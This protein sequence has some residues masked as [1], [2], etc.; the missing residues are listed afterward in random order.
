MGI[1]TV[2][3]LLFKW[4]LLI[5]HI[6]TI[7]L[8]IFGHDGQYLHNA[9]AREPHVAVLVLGNSIISVDRKCK[10]CLG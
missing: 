6:R 9:T 7:I 10:D 1:S 8:H 2:H 3:C 5:Y 4:E